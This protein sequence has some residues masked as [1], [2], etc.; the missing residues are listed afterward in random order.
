M[1]LLVYLAIRAEQKPGL[2]T[3]FKVMG[4]DLGLTEGCLRSSCRALKS[5][6]LVQIES[7]YSEEGGQQANIYTLTPRARKVISE[8][9]V[10]GW[11]CLE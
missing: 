9:Q 2:G 3:S 8:L 6:G 5:E 1:R 10:G 7:R 11:K 4:N